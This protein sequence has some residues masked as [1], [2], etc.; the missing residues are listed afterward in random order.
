MPSAPSIWPTCSR[1][2]RACAISSRRESPAR[3]H[4]SASDST[5]RWPVSDA[6]NRVALTA[7]RSRPRTLRSLSSS[8]SFTSFVLAQLEEVGDITARSMF[9]GVGLYHRGVFFALIARDTLYLKVGD[10]NRA[11]YDRV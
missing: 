7:K 2:S 8:D 3:A 4:M 1:G 10:A 5:N 11:D 9:G 6:Y